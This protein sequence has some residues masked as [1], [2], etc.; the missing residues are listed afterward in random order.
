MIY[1]VK[2]T[3]K[4]SNIDKNNFWKLALELFRK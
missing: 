4:N 2:D 1:L 3:N